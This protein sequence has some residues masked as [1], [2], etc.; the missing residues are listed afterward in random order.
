VGR[1]EPGVVEKQGATDHEA[2]TISRRDILDPLLDVTCSPSD[3]KNNSE[4]ALSNKCQNGARTRY[5]HT[6]FVAS[7]SLRSSIDPDLMRVRN[8]HGHVDA[9]GRPTVSNRQ[10]EMEGGVSYFDMHTSSPR[11]FVLQALSRAL[12]YLASWPD[13]PSLSHGIGHCGACQQHTAC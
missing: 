1:H 12:P 7:S 3:L 4:E 10:L 13:P 11:H 6:G 9:R 8:V 5:Y 2:F